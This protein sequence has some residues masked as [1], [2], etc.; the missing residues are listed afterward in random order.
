MSDSQL[1]E[2]SLSFDEVGHNWNS[3]P[4]HFPISGSK[5]KQLTFN[6]ASS[7]GL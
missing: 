7:C 1:S 3:G 5:T 6:E 2:S 4:S